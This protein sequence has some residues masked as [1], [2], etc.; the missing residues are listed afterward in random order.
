MDNS[1]IS[2]IICCNLLPRHAG[3]IKQMDSKNLPVTE[4]NFDCVV[5]NK[6][7]YARITIY[8]TRRAINIYFLVSVIEG[9]SARC[10]VGN[11]AC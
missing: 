6:F 4:S 1:F 8:F 7:Y 5:T 2:Y 10:Y 11:T 9:C 3:I